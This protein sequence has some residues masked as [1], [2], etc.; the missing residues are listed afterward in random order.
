MI[1]TDLQG[2]K[3]I[4][5]LVNFLEGRYPMNYNLQLKMENGYWV[6]KKYV[7]WLQNQI[8]NLYCRFLEIIIMEF[9][10]FISS[11]EYKKHINK[12]YVYNQEFSIGNVVIELPT[13][14]DDLIISEFGDN[15]RPL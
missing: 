7:L 14:V 2:S 4:L 10:N 15:N 3:M 6:L 5:T 11:R 1:R 12:S 9:E 13:N 8:K